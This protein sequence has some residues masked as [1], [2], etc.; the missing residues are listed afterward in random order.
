MDKSYFSYIRVSTARQGHTGTSLVEQQASIRRHAEQHGLTI[1]REYEEQETAA[2]RGRPIFTQMLKAL[3]SGA[4]RGVI[5]HKIDRSARNLKDWADLGEL[6]DAGCEVRFA[7]ESLDLNSRGGRLSADIQAVVA[8][9]YIRNLREETKKGFYGRIKQ[10]L[11]PMPARIGYLDCGKGLPKTPDPVHAPLVRDAFELYASGK[12]TLDRLVAEMHKRG[13]RNK[14]GN[15]VSR[16][17]LATM[18]KNPF[19]SGLIR[20]YTT[21]EMYA[22]RHEPL[23]S[24]QLFRRTQSV[25]EGKGAE[26]HHRNSFL[27]RRHL[28]C[29]RCVHTLIGETQKSFIY[30]RCHTRACPQKTIREELI[31]SSFSDALKRLRFDER[32]MEYCYHYIEGAYRTADERVESHAKSLDLQLKGISERLSKL[33]DALIDGVIERE[34]YVAKKN[35]LLNCEQD[36]K[37]K[38][39]SVEAGERAVLGKTKGFLEQANDAYLS[40]KEGMFEDKRDLVKTTTSNFIVEYKTVMPK[41]YLPF[42]LVA[43]RQLSPSGSPY[44]AEGRTLSLLLSQLCGYFREHDVEAK[45]TFSNRLARSGSSLRQAA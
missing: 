13:L 1:T 20:L 26:K 30:Y 4:A 9:D 44:R 25:F 2:K 27:F 41:L 3:K 7:N 29:Q 8:S 23:I 42:Q 11:Y 28:T 35:H 10:G 6:I 33:T 18:L 16:N 12:W 34:M 24:P 37:E 40:Y 5:I 39:K 15:K 36:L 43:E 45:A 32:E 14:R 31:E 22:G 17:G 38:L 19:Y 21:G